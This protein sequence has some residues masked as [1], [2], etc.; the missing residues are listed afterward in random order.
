MDGNALSNI[1]CRS[2]DHGSHER[3]WIE[4]DTQYSTAPIY[5]NPAISYTFKQPGP[6]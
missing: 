6:N 1:L 2:F 5:A 4:F 3:L